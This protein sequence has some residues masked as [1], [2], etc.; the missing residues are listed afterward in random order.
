MFPLHSPW[1][2]SLSLVHHL[3]QEGVLGSF[4]SRIGQ[5]HS[6]PRR[7]HPVTP[8]RVQGARQNRRCLARLDSDRTHGY[9]DAT[10]QGL[11][12]RWIDKVQEK[13]RKNGAV[14][15]NV[16][17]HTQSHLQDVV[18]HLIWATCI[19]FAWG[20][21]SS[22]FFTILGIYNYRIS[23][24]NTRGPTTHAATSGGPVAGLFEDNATL[25]KLRPR[26]RFT[27]PAPLLFDVLFPDRCIGSMFPT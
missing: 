18:G 12:G 1:P 19:L 14:C 4:T 23:E 6:R 9:S 15:F 13:L 25:A 7:S 16:K 26:R 2:Y 5:Q 21:P 22:A 3:R 17:K 27:R 24:R 8:G 11:Q 20:C 10:N